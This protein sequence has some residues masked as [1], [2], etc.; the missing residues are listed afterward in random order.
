MP[1]D[2]LG[3][4]LDPSQPAVPRRLD[5]GELGDGSGELRLVHADAGHA[6]SAQARYSFSGHAGGLKLEWAF[7]LFDQLKGYVQVTSG[8]GESLIDYNHRQN[9]IGLGVLLLPW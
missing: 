9:T 3:D 2:R 1:F 5:R 7:P 4:L 6:L 8:Y